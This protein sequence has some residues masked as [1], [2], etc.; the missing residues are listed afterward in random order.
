MHLLPEMNASI[1]W[2]FLR[3]RGNSNVGFEDLQKVKGRLKKYD[4]I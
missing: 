1:T 3:D 4:E 2:D